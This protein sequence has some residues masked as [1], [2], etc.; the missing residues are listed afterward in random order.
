MLRSLWS[1]Q[2]TPIRLG[3][4]YSVILDHHEVGC[5]ADRAQP[6]VSAAFH[7][8]LTWP[9]VFPIEGS[10]FEYHLILQATFNGGI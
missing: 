6:H 8:H 3:W 4:I 2:A 7:L 1:L 9:I 5:E 10:I